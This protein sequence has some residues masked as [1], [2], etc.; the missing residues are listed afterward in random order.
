[1]KKLYSFTAHCSKNVRLRQQL[2]LLLSTLCWTLVPFAAAGMIG[3][4][5]GLP[6]IHV[7][8]FSL[9]AAGF[10]GIFIGFFG[11]FVFL[12]RKSAP[13]ENGQEEW[14]PEAKDVPAPKAMEQS[15]ISRRAL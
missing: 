6:L 2:F 7:L 8:S 12:C 15:R 4:L 13:S 1:M 9:T 3:L 5:F 11:G 10:G 14:K